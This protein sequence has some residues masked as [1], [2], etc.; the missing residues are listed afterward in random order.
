MDTSFK[1]IGQFTPLLFIILICEYRIII[2][3]H[4]HISG[5]M[6]SNQSRIFDIY[7]GSYFIEADLTQ[8]IVFIILLFLFSKFKISVSLGL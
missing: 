6:K 4:L 1:Y 2:Y 5:F 3:T 8:G 7:V